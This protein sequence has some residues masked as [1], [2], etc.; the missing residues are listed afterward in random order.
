M[1][2][3]PHTIIGSTDERTECECC[4]RTGLKRTIVIRETTADESRVVYYGTECAAR[5]AGRTAAGIRREALAADRETAR[6]VERARL[7]AEHE[8]AMLRRAFRDLHALKAAWAAR[9]G[10]AVEF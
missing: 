3:T 1:T 2:T 7:I 5:A 8:A 10:V 4:G 6:E 9:A